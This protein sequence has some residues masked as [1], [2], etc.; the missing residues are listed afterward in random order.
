MVS[1]KCDVYTYGI[2][3]MEVFTRVTPDND[4]FGR[5][6]GENLS[7]RSWVNDSL[8]QYS[9]ADIVDA[10]LLRANE[11]HF[12]EK[13]EC[14]SSIMEV[15]LICTRESYRERNTM[16][17]VTV[18]LENVT[19]GLGYYSTTHNKLINFLFHS[20]RYIHTHIYILTQSRRQIHYM[21]Y[22]YIC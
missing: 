2:M 11:E 12:N 22:I 7:L 9:L 16:K 6:G 18:S 17:D 3:L 4:T 20:C 14:V 8:Q 10:N 13:M 5:D 1:T 19:S 21:P 15:A